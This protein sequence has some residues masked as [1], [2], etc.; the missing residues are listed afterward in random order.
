MTAETG[1][2]VA[3]GFYVTMETVWREVAA[4]RVEV[5]KALSEMQEV[6]SRN[7]TADGQHEDYEKRLRALERF[8]YKLVGSFIVVEIGLGIL[9]YFLLNHK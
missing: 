1:P 5:N 2:P 6:R 3:P 4:T 9:E 7:K 8:Q